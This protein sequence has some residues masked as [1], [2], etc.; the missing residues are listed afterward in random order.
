[1]TWRGIK[2]AGR[3][4]EQWLHACLWSVGSCCLLCFYKQ[5]FVLF[6]LRFFFPYCFLHVFTFPSSL[7]SFPPPPYFNT[8]CFSP[9]TVL[10]DSSFSL[11][12]VVLFLSVF[13]ILPSLS[14]HSLLYFVVFFLFHSPSPFSI[15]IVFFLYLI[16]P[17]LY[18]LFLISAEDY[19]PVVQS[20]QSNFCSHRNSTVIS[21]SK[22]EVG[23]CFAFCFC[24]SEGKVRGFLKCFL[25]C[26]S[27]ELRMGRSCA[28][29]LYSQNPT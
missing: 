22:P 11:I 13:I 12:C 16:P 23:E 17:F 1:M 25:Q 2:F 15:F 10:C 4:Y 8:V 14:F 19:N 24:R 6:L 29:K 20:V 27:S 18:P 26:P 28:L 21:D 3:L 9:S 7:L 5:V